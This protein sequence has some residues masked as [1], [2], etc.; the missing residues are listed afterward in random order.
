MKRSRLL[1]LGLAA[2]APVYAETFDEEAIFAQFSGSVA[3]V[4]FEGELFDGSKEAAFGTAFLVSADGLVLTCNH[5]VPVDSNYKTS[6]L[7]ARFGS[8]FS[9]PVE[10]EVIWRE[11]KLD[12][13][14]LKFP[15]PSFA[16]PL[17]VSAE[18]ASLLRKGTHVITVGFPIDLDAGVWDGRANTKVPNVPRWVMDTV[19][20][21]GQSG[22]PIFTSDGHIV[23]L[24]WG[25][26]IRWVDGKSTTPLQGIRYFVSGETVWNE[27]PKD[28]RELLSTTVTLPTQAGVSLS[29]LRVANTIDFT[30]LASSANA[31][32]RTYSMPL[33]A[34]KGFR[35]VHVKSNVFNAANLSDYHVDIAQDGQTAVARFSL[36]NGSAQDPWRAWLKGTVQLEQQS[37]DMAEAASPA[38][39][40]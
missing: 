10:G 9:P 26:A 28:K 31:G 40:P 38:A 25:S 11:R 36:N 16:V 30:R 8:L 24:A 29:M 12:V 5:V 4:D 13:A 18:R 34:R 15:P 20:N 23:G 7:T 35:I 21:P 37:L 14:L 1:L 2:I 27:L 19:L 17:A 22:S 32:R 3:R 6:K 39:P 33:V